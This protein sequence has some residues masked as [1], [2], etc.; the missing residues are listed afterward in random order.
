[1]RSIIATA[2]GEPD[3]LTFTQTA[4]PNCDASSVLVDVAYAGVN[5][6][7]TYRRSGLY[8]IP[9]PHIPGSEGAG[10]VTEVGAD[11]SWARVGD[12]V[13]WASTQGSYAEQVVLGAD[14]CYA[15]PD[16]VGLDTAAAAMLQGLTAHYLVTSSVAVVPGTTALVHAGAGGV[17][18]LLTQ[19]AVARG[20]RVITTVSSDEKA[21]LSREAGA[22]DVLRYD[23]FADTTSELPRAVRDLTNGV[24]VDVV[25]DGVGASTFD[26]SLGSL[27]VRGVM[28][29]FGASSG[30]VPPFDLQ[31][32]NRGGALSVT[33]PSLG[34]FLRTLEERAWRAGELFGAIS[35]GELSVR[36]GARFALA[37]ATAAHAALES[38]ATTGKVL[39]T[40]S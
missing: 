15:V 38:R 16:G 24:G 26:G 9:F 30:P 12:R 10:V 6:I 8:P 2:A 3:V 40:V 11:V 34:F 21:S 23:K 4:S 25:Y 37:D 18:L 13:A 14:D 33:R 29:L 28:V 1:M 32:L 31:R 5:F 35:A 7:D 27:A 22:S 36:V 17:G 20:A 39:L 19:M